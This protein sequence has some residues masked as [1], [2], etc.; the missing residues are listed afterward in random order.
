MAVITTPLST[1]K[2]VSISF[3]TQYVDLGIQFVSVIILARILSP[4][5]IGT[6]SVAALLMT[7]L[8]VF[9]DF[10][11]AQYI[12]QETEL[13]TE[14]L[15]RAMGVSI[16][17]AL[18]VAAVVLA[19]S[20]AA[21]RFYENEELHAIFM[22]MSLSFAIS[23]F[24][25]VILGVMRR[26]NRLT[27]IFYIK[28]FSALS[29]VICGIVLA[30]Q[31]MG[32]LSLAWSNFAGILAF[33]IGGNLLRT[34]GLP[35]KPRFDKIGS[36][37][38]FGTI[39]STG[40]LANIIGSSAPE[41]VAGKLMNMAAV[42]YL[43]RAGGLIQLFNRLISNALTPLVLPYFAQMRRDGVDLRGP[44]MAT[45]AHLTAVAWPFFAG[46]ALLAGPMIR[47]LYGHQWDTAVPVAQLLCVGSAIGAIN[48]FATQ[49]MVANGRVRD[50][51]ICNLVIQPVRVLAVVAGALV[52]L[53]QIAAALVAVE[54]FALAVSSFF[55]YKTLNISPLVMLKGCGR[56]SLV[57]LSASVV[58]LMVWLHFGNYPDHPWSVLALGI[59]GAAVGWLGS[60]WV[61][62]H[63]LGKHLFEAI[64][65]PFPGGAQR[66][67]LSPGLLA[68]RLAYGSGLLGLYHAW[69][70][71]HTLTVA[72]F[73]RVLPPTDP[74]YPGADPEWTMTPETFSQCLDFMARHY[75]VVPA[76]SVFA[77][78]D[79]KTTLPPRALLITFDDGW[80]DTAEFAQPVLDRHGLQ[81]LVFVAGGAVNRPTP[82]WEE[83]IFSYLRTAP[84]ALA[85]LLAEMAQQGLP[86]LEHVPSAI[87][88]GAIRTVIA[89][90]SKCDRAGVLAMTARI[91]ADIEAPPAMMDT[92]QLLALIGSGHAIGGHGMTHTPLTRVTDLEDEMR[93]AQS[94]LRLA[95]GRTVIESMSLPHGA[96]SPHVLDECRHAGYRYLFNSESH[97][98][99]VLPGATPASV[100]G[101]IGR[102]HIPEREITRDG[103]VVPGLL[104]TF[105]FR[106]AVAP[107]SHRDGT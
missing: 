93:Q 51:T 43:S 79:G 105:L 77:A 12:I 20:G 97:L 82:F 55:L 27:A 56:S 95:L 28:I 33:G 59:P 100:I 53:V 25:S 63:P 87:D 60:L 47:A 86:D 73:H 102:I 57:A 10:G 32:A 74:R 17:L 14:K 2:A 68:K 44:Y 49:A 91:A 94:T 88:E 7:M 18:A 61:L 15:Q 64:G 29:Q 90:L 39:S 96:S 48:L 104:A 84:G 4:S 101:P 26:E 78:L 72:M 5:E 24:G 106:R 66:E 70:N 75:H 31:G 81:A 8:H 1:R 65:L 35:W 52:G 36:I 107:I 62:R 34:K 16:L 21:A 85:R 69:R 13:S 38:S 45:V 50:S 98:N 3:A 46:L 58:P 103:R 76:S 37:L 42:G 41:L 40:N 22:V 6:F 11:V 19:G 9:R 92:A 83:L 30:W 23:P 89:H 99:T 54:L 80:A 67:A 71:R